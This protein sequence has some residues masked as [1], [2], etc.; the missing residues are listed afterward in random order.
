MLYFM[1][2]LHSSLGTQQPLLDE[3][4]R[5]RREFYSRVV[6]LLRSLT[7]SCQIC[8]S[9]EAIAESL[10]HT[11]ML[12][13]KEVMPIMQT[14]ALSNRL[15]ECFRPNRYRVPPPLRDFVQIWV[16]NE[17]AVR[18]LMQAHTL[19]EAIADVL[20]DPVH[21]RANDLVPGFIT[22]SYVYL[23]SRIRGEHRKRRTQAKKTSQTST[24]SQ[25][26]AC[27][28]D[29]NQ[30]AIE[31]NGVLAEALPGLLSGDLAE[32]AHTYLPHVF[33]AQWPPTTSSSCALCHIDTI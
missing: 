30:Q 3:H 27:D 10:A 33:K 6:Q 32:L 11:A 5:N 9:A 2:V 25:S 14:E 8:A 22:D 28:P 12:L 15:P 17:W 26:N 4:Y 16:N 23:D 21:V 24:R 31:P 1:H 7:G 13:P 19:A 18:L 29:D 20:I